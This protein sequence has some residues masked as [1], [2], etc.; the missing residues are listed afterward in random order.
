[1]KWKRL[2]LGLIGIALFAFILSSIDLAKVA[3]A[4]LGAEKLFL[5]LA[6][7]A[8]IINLLGRGWKFGLAAEFYGEKF[9]LM[10]ATKIFCAGSM[11]GFLT[12]LKA[13][14][15]ARA[16]YF[17]QLNLAK[18]IAAIAVDRASD[19]IAVGLCGLV[20]LAF[21]PLLEKFF[22]EKLLL[23]AAVALV[24]ACV[25]FLL[26]KKFFWNFLTELLSVLHSPFFSLKIFGWGAIN[27][28]TTVIA[29]FFVAASLGVTVPVLPFLAIVAA[30][31][32][33]ELFPVTFLGLGTRE[34]GLITLLSLYSVPAETAVAL[35]LVFL[36]IN[37][38]TLSAIALTKIIET[39]L[40]WM[41]IFP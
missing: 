32:F 18:R 31:L 20:G 22:L 1:M 26:L 12:P 3:E 41:E 9:T 34:A 19:M 35:S 24:G 29:Y 16:F 13:G 17:K 8:I 30:V 28:L 7:F 23:L 14:I 37:Y 39:P 15:L 21:F 38:A 36:F 33:I 5:L 40:K 27:F 10:D 25:L 2:L 11:I 4:V 6:F